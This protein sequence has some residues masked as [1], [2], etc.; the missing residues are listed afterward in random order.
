MP[1]ISAHTISESG[2]YILMS[3]RNHKYFLLLVLSWGLSAVLRVPYFQYQFIFVDEAW[4]ANGAKVLLRGGQLYKDIWLDKNPPIF[5]FCALLFKIFGIN[6]IAIHVGSLLL[7]CIISAV[8]FKLGTRFFSA[9]VGAGAALIYAVASTTYYIPRM[10]GM[11]TETLMVVFTSLAAFSCLLGLAGCR[12]SGFLTAGLFASFALLTKPVAVTE[13]VFL[14]LF[15]GS[16]GVGGFRA[17]FRNLV[18]LATGYAI[19]FGAF[20]VYLYR[21]GMLS[22]WWEQAVLFG[23]RYVNEVSAETFFIKSLRVSLAFVLIFAW[24]LI[25]IWLSRSMRKPYLL[26]YTF[27]ACWLLSAFAG[28][29]LSRRYFASYFIQVMPAL[30]LLGAVGLV[31]IWNNR[32][33]ARIRL[34]GKA[35]C[36]A[37]LVSFAWFH[38]RTLANWCHLISPP[39][40]Q[41]QQWSMWHENQRNLEIAGR[42][43]RGTSAYDR[44]FIW[45]SNPELFFLADRSPATVWTDY[46]VMSG[47]PPRAGERPMLAQVA[48]TIS[49][50]RPRYVLDA[51]RMARLETCPELRGLVEKYY[52][53]EVEVDGVRLF[54]LRQGGP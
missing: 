32:R 33:Q 30:S 51:Q 5:W 52:D 18:L 28:V 23:F 37:L 40:H 34:D 29:V 41:V 10:I 54:R 27:V 16:A 4:W 45:G 12:R 3:I 24:L 6:M 50:L 7:V 53:L 35:C 49:R 47:N 22:A 38:A 2:K 14:V 17:R 25:L 8:L 13:T 11:N 31:Y 43:R 19:G 20:L 48:A 15:V 42:L 46:D 39:V 9:G 44:I 21:A 36:A 26:A 1:V